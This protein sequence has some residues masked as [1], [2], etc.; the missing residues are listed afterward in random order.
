MQSTSH[1]FLVT[2]LMIGI[3]FPVLQEK[4]QNRQISYILYKKATR[5]MQQCTTGTLTTYVPSTGS[6]ASTTTNKQINISV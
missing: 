1:T 3:G 2:N 4:E 6:T 5:Q